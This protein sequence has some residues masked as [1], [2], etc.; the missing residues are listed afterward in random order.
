MK[1]LS[2]LILLAMLVIFASCQNE[3]TEDQ[4]A[5]EQRSALRFDEKGNVVSDGEE[6]KELMFNENSEILNQS[7]MY[8]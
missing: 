6:D 4:A 3:S 7:H 5:D 8:R 2:K 1:Q